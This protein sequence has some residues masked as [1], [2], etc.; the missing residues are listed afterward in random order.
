MGFLWASKSNID[1]VARVDAPDETECH[2]AFGMRSSMFEFVRV[3]SPGGR[4]AN[5]KLSHD[6]EDSPRD[7]AQIRNQRSTFN[8]QREV[9]SLTA[10]L[11]LYNMFRSA[12]T[13]IITSHHWQRCRHFSSSRLDPIVQKYA[14]QLAKHQPCFSMASSNIHILYEPSAFYRCLLV[15]GALRAERTSHHFLA[16]GYDQASRETYLLVFVICWV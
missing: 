3:V 15:G 16:L 12:G 5:L 10:P 2:V 9:F 1:H 4:S 11:R 14:T 7:L 6:Q 13:R 8:L